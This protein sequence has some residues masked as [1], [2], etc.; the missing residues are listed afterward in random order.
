VFDN[1]PPGQDVRVALSAADGRELFARTI[2]TPA[3]VR[4]GRLVLHPTDDGAMVDFDLEEPRKLTV[5][6]HRP[7]QEAPAAEVSREAGPRW[8][9]HVFTG[10]RPHT[11]YVLRAQD[12]SGWSVVVD[13]PFETLRAAHRT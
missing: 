12:T 11:A 9:H 5:S 2:K 8:F 1:L 6:I 3:P 4:T 13:Y 7:G 10:L